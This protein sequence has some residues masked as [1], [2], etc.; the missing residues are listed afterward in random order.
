MVWPKTQRRFRRR[1]G[2]SPCDSSEP[3]AGG[4]EDVGKAG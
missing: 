3:R 1:L 2:R 4:W